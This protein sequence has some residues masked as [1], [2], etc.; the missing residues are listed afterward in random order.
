MLYN[1]FRHQI[2]VAVLLIALLLA[3]FPAVAQGGV[4][5]VA[6]AN[7]NLRASASSGS[8]VLGTVPYQT[9]LQA[10]AISG[11]RLWVAVVYNGQGGWL[12]LSYTGVV[13][14]SLGALSVSN[15]TFTAGGGGQVTSSVMVSPPS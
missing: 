9:Q 15:Q 5:V 14:G 13:E 11:D 3:A 2:I 8:A 10:T 12:S 1:R 7:L 6:N 4:T